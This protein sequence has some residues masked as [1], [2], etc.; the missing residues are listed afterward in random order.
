LYDVLDAKDCYDLNYSLYKPEVACELISTLSMRFS[1]CNMASHYC[2]NVFYCDQC[3]NSGNLFGCIGLNHEE[4]C[5]LNKQYTK[6][7]YESLVS[8]LKEHM[9]NLGE[10]GEF[11]PA[12]I[13]PFSY[14]ETV[15]Q[16]YYPLKKELAEK[17]GYKWV[18]IPEKNFQGETVEIPDAI[19]DV[20]E[21]ISE[22]I[23]I[24]STSKRPYKV[25]PVELELYKKLGVPVPRLHPDERHKARIAKR[26]PRMLWDATC[27][28]CSVSIKTSYPPGKVEKLYCETCYK[29]AV[30]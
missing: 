19:D 7:E 4:Y 2:N 3:N 9:K 16:E 27:S 22:K 17:R 11:F 24:C 26:N 30:Y 12:S 8:R 18:E 10:W 29:K 25:L 5:I 20:S 6:E 13:N 28:S 21:T 1:A 23:L 14:N 15:A